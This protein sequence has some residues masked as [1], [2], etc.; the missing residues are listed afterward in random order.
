[1]DRD[2]LLTRLKL[3]PVR[4]FM[5]DGPQF[6]I[7][8]TEMCIVDQIGAYVLQKVDGVWKTQILALV[9]MNRIEQLESVSG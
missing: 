7:P 9:C 6:D 5:N 8:S 3:G 4:V 1:M 2:T